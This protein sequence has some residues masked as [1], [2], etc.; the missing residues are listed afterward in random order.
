MTPSQP[1]TPFRE[2]LRMGIEGA[3]SNL[4]PGATLWL[5]GLALVVS[6]YQSE[7][8]S[9]IF[10]A[11][12]IWKTK[13]S[14]WFAILSTAT[15]GSLIPWLVQMLFLPLEKR[16]PFRQVPWLF[17]FWGMHGWQ[18]DVFYQLQSHL[19]GDN[20]D[21]N[22]ILSKTLVDEFVWVPFLVVPQILLSYL[23]IENALSPSR[24]REALR[25]K[26]FFARAIPLMIANWVVWIPSVA[27]IYLFPLPL[28]LPLQNLILAMW[29]LIISFFTKNA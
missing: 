24:F 14:P 11:I 17:L 4:L 2:A 23:F 22:T 20:I 9:E 26:G 12:G 3:K 19:F 21:F 7:S 16:V 13:V 29:C 10:D 6:Y 25:H 5:F 27:L 15:F 8:I 18:V 28:Q 1:T